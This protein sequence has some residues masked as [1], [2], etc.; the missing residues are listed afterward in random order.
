MDK[1]AKKQKRAEAVD[2]KIF[3]E[4]IMEFMKK[5][6]LSKAQLADAADIS[7]S[8]LTQF[9]KNERKPSADAVVKLASILGTSTDYLLGKVNLAEDLTS[10]QNYKVKELVSLFTELA[11]SD[12]ERVLKM[13]RDMKGTARSSSEE[14]ST[15]PLPVSRE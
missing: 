2:Q 15:N 1:G 9:L 4:R 8:A 3:V 14:S 10:P 5:D 11:D 12:Q 6:S 13:I 7:R